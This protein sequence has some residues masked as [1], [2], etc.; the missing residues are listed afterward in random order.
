MN[1]LPIASGLRRGPTGVGKMCGMDAN[2]RHFLHYP[3]LNRTWCGVQGESTPLSQVTC[4]ACLCNV[5]FFELHRLSGIA[6]HL[7]TP[8]EVL[9]SL[10]RQLNMIDLP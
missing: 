6:T 7:G 5:V 9:R 1:I 8:P 2:L 10:A 4:H 3:D